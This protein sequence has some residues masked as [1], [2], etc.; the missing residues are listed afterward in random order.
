MEQKPQNFEFA[1][2]EEALAYFKGRHYKDENFMRWCEENEHL[3]YQVYPIVS[4]DG[5]LTGLVYDATNPDDT[6]TIIDNEVAM[7]ESPF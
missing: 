4:A 5:K 3:F 7:E 2:L 6:Y 1:T